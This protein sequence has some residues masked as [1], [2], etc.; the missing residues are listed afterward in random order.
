MVY[1]LISSF[2]AEHGTIV[3]L[4]TIPSI[5][6]G[7]YHEE[8]GIA[9]LNYF[10]L[11]VGL[12]GASQLNARLMDRIY[13]YFTKKNGGKGKPEYRLRE[14]RWNLRPLPRR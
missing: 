2:Y 11:G 14:C 3:F 1:T 12:T 10:A 9:G 4:T 7:I 13:V 8:V 6:E 5:F